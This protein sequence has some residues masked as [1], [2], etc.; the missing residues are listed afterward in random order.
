[1]QNLGPVSRR[2]PRPHT[3]T[4]RVLDRARVTS[5]AATGIE[6]DPVLVVTVGQNTSEVCEGHQE[7]QKQIGTT[8]HN[9]VEGP[10][11]EQHRDYTRQLGEQRPPGHTRPGDEHVVGTTLFADLTLLHAA[12]GRPWSE[13][14]PFS[15]E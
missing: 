10:G 9:T 1:M 15:G 4:Q 12:E 7:L 5:L 14:A 11:Q 3:T 13:H 6:I 8:Q 2:Q